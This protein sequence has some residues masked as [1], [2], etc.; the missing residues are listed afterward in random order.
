M[1]YTSYKNYFKWFYDNNLFGRKGNQYSVLNVTYDKIVQNF[2]SFK[3]ELI[4]NANKLCETYPNRKFSIF[5]SGGSESETIIRTYKEANIDFTSYIFRYEDDI[6]LYDVSYAISACE[7]IGASYKVIDFNLEKFYNSSEAE[8]I[9]EVA[10]I[11]YPKALVHCKFLDYIEDNSFIIFGC[12]ATGY[13]RKNDDYTTTGVWSNEVYDFELG[14]ERFAIAYNRPVCFGWFRFTPELVLS[15]HATSWAKNL[16][17]D[18]YYKKTGGNSTKIWGYKEAF[19]E[20]LYREKKTGFEG[21]TSRI[22]TILNEYETF[23]EKKYNGLIYRGKFSESVDDMY[24]KMLI[25]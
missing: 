7:S 20:I 18:K 9:S 19:P 4:N 6:N 11:D 21:G 17:S 24:K 2:N 10:Q 12:G 22:K 8:K 14:W 13:H 16:R 23:L 25:S 5:L 1:L 15:H 3:I